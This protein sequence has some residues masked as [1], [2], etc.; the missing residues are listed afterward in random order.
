[1]NAYCNC[2]SQRLACNIGYLTT[3]PWGLLKASQ[4]MFTCAALIC[5]CCLGTLNGTAYYLLTVLTLAIVVTII[6][7]L[8]NSLYLPQ[9]LSSIPFGFIE[10]VYCVSF[11]MLCFVGSIASFVGAFKKDSAGPTCFAFA[12][13]FTLSAS[14]AYL[15]NSYLIFRQWQGT[16]WM[17]LTEVKA[18]ESIFASASQGSTQPTGDADGS[19]RGSY[20]GIVVQVPPTVLPPLY[21]VTV[22]PAADQPIAYSNYD[23]DADS[24]ETDKIAV[25]DEQT[26]YSFD[27]AVRK[28]HEL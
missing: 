16:T 10:L 21:T 19:D 24:D 14:A 25:S 6:S 4:L 23:S 20:G 27:D 26:G 9:K 12:T 22:A 7:T 2:G 11:S 1:M 28:F 17:S 3:W 13:I 15:A 5:V 8:V 18:D